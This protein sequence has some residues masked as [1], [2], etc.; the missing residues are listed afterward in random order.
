MIWK[1]KVYTLLIIISELLFMSKTKE[2][3]TMI[4]VIG[5]TLMISNIIIEYTREKIRQENHDN[6][7]MILNELIDRNISDENSDI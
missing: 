4:I 2:Y 5:I 6:I 3:F 1:I 7:E